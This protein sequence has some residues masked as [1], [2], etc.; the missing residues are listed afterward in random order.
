MAQE[1]QNTIQVGK[2]APAFSN[3]PCYHRG[4]K[5]KVSL[6]DYQGKWLVLFFYPHDFTF[7][8]PTE[9]EEFAKHYEDF[10]NINCEIVSAST[11]SVYSHK[12][13]FETDTRL[14]KVMYPIIA[15]TSH[16]L[17]K[18]FNVMDDEGVAQ[19]GTFIIDPEGILRY[20]LVSDGSV[21]RNILETLRVVE[22]LQTGERCPATWKRGDRTLGK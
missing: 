8:C 3:M 11:D 2:P 4:G 9:I 15:D 22:A 19:R 21:G 18:K 13:W 12:A 7:I 5:I 14:H 6:A 17:A 16:E 20:L 10:K 1:S